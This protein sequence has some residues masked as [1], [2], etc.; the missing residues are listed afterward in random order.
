MS[1]SASPSI[2][3]AKTPSEPFT[4]YEKFVVGLIAMLN[5]TV[6][7][8]FMILSPLGAM[9]IPEL[10]VSTAEFGKVVSGYAFAAVISGLLAAGFADRFD[11][12]HLLLFFYGG[13]IGGTLL[14]ALASSYKFLLIAR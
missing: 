2:A 6:I 3:K 4:P 7:L 8:D 5:F 11:R 9:L 10:H 14:C 12:K 1:A 13:F